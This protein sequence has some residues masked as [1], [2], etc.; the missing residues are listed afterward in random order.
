MKEVL[1]DMEFNITLRFFFIFLL[2]IYIIFNVTSCEMKK[3]EK[4]ITLEELKKPV[5]P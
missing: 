3:I 1:K 2:I 5:L 4:A